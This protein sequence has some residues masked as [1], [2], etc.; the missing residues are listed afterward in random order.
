[1]HFYVMSDWQLLHLTCFSCIACRS[2]KRRYIWPLFITIC[3]STISMRKCQAW[4]SSDVPD[5]IQQQYPCQDQVMKLSQGRWLW[6]FIINIYLARQIV[7][8]LSHTT[9]VFLQYQACHWASQLGLPYLYSCVR[10]IKIALICLS[11]TE[12]M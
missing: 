9:I 4:C 10:Y 8:S 3:H 5:N 7:S 2:I 6:P 12:S 1:M 11:W